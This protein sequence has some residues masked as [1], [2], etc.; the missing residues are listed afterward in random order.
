VFHDRGSRAVVADVPRLD[1]RPCLTLTLI[2]VKSTLMMPAYRSRW[3]VGIKLIEGRIPR[4]RRGAG[5]QLAVI[6]LIGESGAVGCHERAVRSRS[7]AARDIKVVRPVD[8]C[9][10]IGEADSTTCLATR[11]TR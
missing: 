10:V 1:E 6:R 7:R 5:R 4:W 8:A 3:G 11:K 2:S 9:S